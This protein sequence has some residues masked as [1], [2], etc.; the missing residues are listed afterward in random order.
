[1]RA[2]L[3]PQLGERAAMV[4]AFTYN[5]QAHLLLK[6][7]HGICTSCDCLF[8]ALWPTVAVLH[9]NAANLNAC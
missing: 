1:M 7:Y 8:L 3:P 5:R 2:Q 4:A 6:S 9:L